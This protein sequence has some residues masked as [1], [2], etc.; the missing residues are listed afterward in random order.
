MINPIILILFV[1]IAILLTIAGLSPVA[2]SA[3]PS[4]VFKNR[5]KVIK[6]NKTTI[7][8]NINS[9]DADREN[10]TLKISKIVSSDNKGIFGLPIILKLIENNEVI[11][12]IPDNK[13]AIFNLVFKKPVKEPEIP[14]AIVA[15]ISVK[16]GL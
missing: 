10:G 9:L 12:K 7:N 15:K 8:I 4:F 16:N 5:I 11:V 1:F 3:N 13:G 14:P 2:L 6:T